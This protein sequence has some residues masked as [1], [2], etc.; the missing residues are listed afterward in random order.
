MEEEQVMNLGRF[1]GH[2]LLCSWEEDRI[3]LDFVAT[4]TVRLGKGN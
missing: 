4:I 2:P 3:L 1:V